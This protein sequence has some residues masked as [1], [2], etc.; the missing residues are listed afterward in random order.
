M[1]FDYCRASLTALSNG[2]PFE[3]AVKF[4][5][6]FAI[7]RHGTPGSI[8]PSMINS[9]NPLHLP[10]FSGMILVVSTTDSFKRV[11]VCK[12][13]GSP[14]PEYVLK[15]LTSNRYSLHVNHV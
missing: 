12:P 15:L 13:P 5:L 3:E 8:V 14:G 2:Y 4:G 1:S 11:Q 10:P 7:Q 9:T 6:N